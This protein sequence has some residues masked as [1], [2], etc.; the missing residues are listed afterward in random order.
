MKYELLKIRTLIK[1][2]N[3]AKK[4]DAILASLLFSALAYF[5]NDLIEKVMDDLGVPTYNYEIVEVPDGFKFLYVEFEDTEYVAFRGTLFS[6]WS[7]TKRVLNFLPK[8]DRD[9]VKMHRGFSMAFEDC[10]EVLEHLISREKPVIFTGHSLGGALALIA[11]NHY[12]ESAVTFAAPNVFFNQNMDGKVDHVG[13]RIKG[14]FVPHLPPTTF[15]FKWTRAKIEFMIDS[16]KK[17]FK[18]TKYHDLGLYISTLL[19]RYETHPP[20]EK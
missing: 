18:Q 5:S 6:M 17:Y 13:Y 8:K 15:F 16:K 11:A 10:N 12:R 4:A 3:E 2:V 20:K 7:N 19:E 14:D 1:T 9:G